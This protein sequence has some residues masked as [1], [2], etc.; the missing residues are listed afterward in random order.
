[1]NLKK[2]GRATKKVFS[3][4]I[5]TVLLG[6]GLNGCDIAM[7]TPPLPSVESPIIKESTSDQALVMFYVEIPADT[8]AEETVLLSVLD[9]VTGLALNTQRYAMTL[10]EDRYYM[11]GVPVTVGAV[12]KYRYSRQGSILAEEHISDNRPVRYRLYRV[13]GPGEVHDVITRWN[14]TAFSGKTGRITGTVG[15][16]AN[17]EPIPNILITAGGAQALTTG[18]GKFFIEGLPPGTH[19]LV[20][21]ATDGSYSTFQQGA[22]VSSDSNTQA[23]IQLSL[24]PRVDVAFLVHVPEGTPPIVPLR[25]A[26]NLSFLGNTYANLS[27][28]ISTLA[29]EMPTLSLLP[30]GSY[31][32]I[33]SLPLGSDIRYKFTLGDGFW[34]AERSTDSAFVIR[35]LIVN[36]QTSVV[37]DYVQT[38]SVGTTAPITF[39]ITVPENTPPDEDIYIQFNPYGWTEPIPMWH[40]G[41]QR[42]AYILYSPIDMIAELGYRYCRA[43][44]CGH[45]DDARTP[46]AFS[47]GQITHPNG[48]PIGLTDAIESWSWLEN[49]LPTVEVSDVKI[50]TRA[51]D[52]ITGF[53][54]QP[55]YHPSW[56]SSYSNALQDIA[57]RGGNQVILPSSWTFTRLDPPVLEPV[58]GQNPLW[59]DITSTVA[60]AKDL[61]LSVA[62]HAIPHF[63]TAVDAW[64]YSA[65][66][67]FAWWVSWF[68]RFETFALHHADLAAQSGADTLILGGKWMTPALPEGKLADGQ[69][70]SVPLDAD[71]RYR[72]LIAKIRV[73]FKGTLAW[74]LPYSK[75]ITHP[76]RFIDQVDQIYVLWS[77][78]LSQDQNATPEVLQAESER[79]I[80][81]EIYALRLMWEPESD[82]KSIVL[83]VAYPSVQG[84]FTGCLPD[85]IVTCLEPEALNFP[86][87]D[88]PLLNTSFEQQAKAYDA[89]LAA[90]NQHDWISGVIS[91][92]YYPPAILHDKST[93]VHGK[94]SADVLRYWFTH[95]TQSK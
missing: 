13:D 57:E 19:N 94:P 40:L 46:G 73:R 63:P 16:S 78:P 81:D 21:Y 84:A 65:P 17:G 93:S 61:N 20:A 95:F 37:E 39:D 32:I 72:E 34:N 87:P 70:S 7:A 38:W 25:M 58:A 54:F 29:S 71:Q 48:E 76:P 4:L 55:M 3:G 85:P 66:R 15:D 86:A 51:S 35:Q 79:I 60:Q 30:D 68:D 83:S 6:V 23:S 91:R 74:A 49:E 10:V 53:E 14:D 77:A 92:G 62:L 45:A 59:H 9:E 82:K 36:E 27:G 89:V 2:H 11:V 56:R 64:W 75:D 22:T 8:P 26:G 88:F 80:N 33:L 43:A 52:F 69:T 47:S 67:D 18:D 28:G 1:M 90:T 42:W 41:G 44:Q 31:G 24:A 12:L 5:A 50:R